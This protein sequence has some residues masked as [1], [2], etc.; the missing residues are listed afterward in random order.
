MRSKDVR[1]YE[2]QDD[3]KTRKIILGQSKKDIVSLVK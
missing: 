2:K 1:E 3:C